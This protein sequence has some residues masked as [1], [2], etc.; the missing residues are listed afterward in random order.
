M[1]DIDTFL[2][3]VYSH[4]A[5]QATPGASLESKAHALERK[6]LSRGNQYRY[7]HTLIRAAALQHELN[8]G[9]SIWR[10]LG[11]SSTDV[12]HLLSLI[13]PETRA[14]LCLAFLGELPASIVLRGNQGPSAVATFRRP[15]GLVFPRDWKDDELKVE[16]PILSHPACNFLVCDECGA[17]PDIA[18]VEVP[19]LPDGLRLQPLA[20]QEYQKRIGHNA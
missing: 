2:G 15:A 13:H 9:P 17:F 6:L 5:V 14:A 16:M 1:S 11:F 7:A 20:A 8:G 18:L 4:P 10:T 3:R 19:A 12:V